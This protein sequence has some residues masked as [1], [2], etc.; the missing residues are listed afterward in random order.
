MFL[1][2]SDKDFCYKRCISKTQI[3]LYQPEGT[4]IFL[5]Y[6]S[7]GTIN[8]LAKKDLNT[9]WPVPKKNAGTFWLVEDEMPP[10]ICK[11]KVKVTIKVIN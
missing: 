5:G 1:I 4:S 10:V 8:S 7:E 3:V 2:N 11:I 9:F 6:Q